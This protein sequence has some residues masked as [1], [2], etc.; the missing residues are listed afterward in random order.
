MARCLVTGGAGF[1]G[2]HIAEALLNEDHEVVILDNLSNGKLE[3]ICNQKIIRGTITNTYDVEKTIKDVEFIFHEAALISVTE[4]MKD[5]KQTLLVNVD[6]SK[7]LI[8]AAVKHGVEKIILASSAAVYGAS[9]PPLS[10]NAKTEPLSPYGESKLIMEKTA[11]QYAEQYGM[12]FSAL[13]YFNVYGPRQ[14]IHSQYSGVISNFINSLMNEKQPVVH[15][16]GK[17]TRD[18]IYVKDVAAANL[19]SMKTKND[20]GQCINIATG[21]PISILELLETIS[22]IMK[23]DIKP[24]IQEPREGDIK[25]SFADVSKAKQLLNFEA[26]YSLEKGLK[27]TIESWH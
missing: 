24:K 23:K 21:K 6:G 8:E 13:R 12:R 1:I 14:N 7:N 20:D 11:S 19:L 27:E 3:N 15:G 2:S 4:S 9:P 10:E 18:F 26:H 25:Y 5:P 17:Q 22:K 16:D